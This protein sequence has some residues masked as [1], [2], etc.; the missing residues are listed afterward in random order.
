MERTLIIMDINFCQYAMEVRDKF[1]Y[2]LVSNHPVWGKV[3]E[4]EIV[5]FFFF[6]THFSMLYFNSFP[7]LWPRVN[8]FFSSPAVT[9]VNPCNLFTSRGIIGRSKPRGGSPSHR[10]LN[11]SDSKHTSR[12]SAA[13]ATK[14]WMWSVMLLTLADNEAAKGSINKRFFYSLHC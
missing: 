12:T 4:G 3:V 11:F 14:I 8:L 5:I 9:L 6:F 10:R 13:S 7:T 1:I 2:L